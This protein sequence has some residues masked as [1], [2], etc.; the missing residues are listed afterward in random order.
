[1]TSLRDQLINAKQ[2]MTLMEERD[3]F[4]NM[5]DECIKILDENLDVLN[6]M[7]YS[8]ESDR[9]DIII[10]E[11]TKSE[12]VDMAHEVADSSRIKKAESYFIK[13]FFEKKY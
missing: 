5:L 12:L 2:L 3:D 13:R 10:T 6:D 8:L 11:L 4:V 9:E 7:E 1:V